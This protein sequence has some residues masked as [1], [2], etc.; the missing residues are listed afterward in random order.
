LKAC[1]NKTSKTVSAVLEEL[2]IDFEKSY[3]VSVFY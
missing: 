2:Y 3:T 1:D